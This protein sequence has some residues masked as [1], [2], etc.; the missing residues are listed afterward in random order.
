MRVPNLLSFFETLTCFS[1]G[2]F[3]LWLAWGLWRLAWRTA[4]RTA[5]PVFAPSL[6]LAAAPG[7]MALC[8]VGLGGL[9]IAYPFDIHGR[10]HPPAHRLGA[11]VELVCFVL[12]P[13]GAALLA[14][15]KVLASHAARSTQLETHA[16][17]ADSS[18]GGQE[19]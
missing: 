17:S 3:L 18:G 14:L 5:E 9:S 7:M 4:A 6:L 2:L 15:A 11:A 19:Q 10:M 8:F 13:G 12:L 1:I 16:E